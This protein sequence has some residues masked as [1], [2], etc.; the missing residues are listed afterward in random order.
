MVAKQEYPTVSSDPD[1]QNRYEL[2]RD[3]G[4]D[5]TFAEMCAFQRPPGHAGT[6]KTFLQGRM[7]NQDLDHMAPINAQ[8]M[9]KRAKRAGIDISGKVHVSSIGPPSMPEAWVS[10]LGDVTDFCKQRGLACTGS[11]SVKG[12]TTDADLM[13]KK[14]KLSKHVIKDHLQRMLK[15]D[16]GLIHKDKRELVEQVIDKHCPKY[17]FTEPVKVEE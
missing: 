1:I 12:V 8:R 3:N 14:P 17:K 11:A 13:P 9:L 15:N 16:P 6:D 7:N 5:H 10:G 4:Q 2:L